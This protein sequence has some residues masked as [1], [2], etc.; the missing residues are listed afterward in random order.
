MKPPSS[1]DH[2]TDPDGLPV[3]SD[4][5][6]IARCRTC[7]KQAIKGGPICPDEE[8]V[9][10]RWRVCCFGDGWSWCDTAKRFMRR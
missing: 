6:T 1:D 5:A 3:T 9:R 10:G 8:M 2:D 4:A 7:G